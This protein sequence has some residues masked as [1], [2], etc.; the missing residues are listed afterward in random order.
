MKRIS[1]VLLVILLC[2]PCSKAMAG[3]E[4]SINGVGARAKAMGGAGIAIADD[5]SA[6]YANPALLAYSGNFA[7]AGGDYIVNS[8]TYKSP[9]SQKIDSKTSGNFVPLAGVN[10][11]ANSRLA[12]GFGVNTPNVFCADFKDSMN[13]YSKISL[14]NIA[15][16]IAYKITDNLALGLSIKA[17][18][19]KVKLTQ[20]VQIAPGVFSRM[21]TDA[22]GWGYSGQIGLS[23]K[24]AT[25]L[26]IGA[27]YQTKTKVSLDGHSN[28]GM[29][30]RSDMSADFYFPGYYGVGVG[31]N[32]GNWLIAADVTRS[33]YGS[34]D[35]VNIDY[36]TWSKSTLALNWEDNTIY[37]F[38]VEY[39]LADSWRLRGG[40]GYQD[41]VIPDSTIN[42]AMP[43]MNGWSVSGG[44]GYRNKKIGVD[45]AYLHA[46]GRERT[47]P[48]PN[49][50]AGKYSAAIDM[51]SGSLSYYW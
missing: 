17:G 35:Q 28:L 50:G 25:W 12:V 24:A 18:Y 44:F 7:Q 10:Y 19:G 6:F 22:D 23:W 47:V 2:W 14:T 31:I 20:P 45:F 1:L 5:A 15:P 37:S 29:V 30:G 11:K 8:F 21:D 33:D 9:A 3:A 46:W 36:K 49:L 34:T 48:L 13:F 27:M 4:N 40:L 26:N 51:L 39:K 32:L 38:G 43:D 42:P 16:A 41:R